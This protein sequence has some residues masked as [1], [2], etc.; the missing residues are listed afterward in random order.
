MLKRILPALTLAVLLT[1]C[2]GTFTNLSATRQPRNANNLY[3]V[4]V[5][6]HSRQQSMRWE[7]IKP[8]VLVGK[9]AYP[10]QK[11]PIA[12]NRWEGLIPVPAGSK[13]IEYRYKFEYDYNV[14]G[15]SPKP[16]SRVSSTYTLK[17]LDQ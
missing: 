14:F 13:E 10:L 1:G 9:E 17:I 2:A 15:G 7:S 16:D 3:P 11:T 4:G 6:F 5:S 8:L 12:E